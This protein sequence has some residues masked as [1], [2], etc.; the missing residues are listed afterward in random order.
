M[1]TLYRHI[2]N[3]FMRPHGYY[4]KMETRRYNIGEI[5]QM[6][7][8]Q[9]RNRTFVIF[10]MAAA[11]DKRVTMMRQV[12]NCLHTVHTSNI[13]YGNELMSATFY[14]NGFANHAVCVKYDDAG[15]GVIDDPGRQIYYAV[16]V[17]NF[18]SCLA[19]IYAVYEFSVI[20]V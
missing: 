18:L 14:K 4:L 5:M 16:N 9:R 15:N 1:C 10:G 8:N 6:S 12:S 20:K 7:V 17:V 11:A 2:T 19:W 3:T 13:P